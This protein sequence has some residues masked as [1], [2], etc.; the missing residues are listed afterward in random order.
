[1]IPHPSGRPWVVYRAGT[2]HVDSTSVVYTALRTGVH[3]LTGHG[4]DD[5]FD[6]APVAFRDPLP[7]HPMR[8]LAHLNDVRH[9]RGWPLWPAV[10]CET[11]PRTLERDPPT[12]TEGMVP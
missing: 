7:R 5:V 2:R 3:H 1:M 9:L 11:W 4:G 6:C 12:S 8:T 10:T